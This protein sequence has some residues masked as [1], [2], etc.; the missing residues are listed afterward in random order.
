MHIIVKN[1]DLKAYRYKKDAGWRAVCRHVGF[2]YKN[3]MRLLKTA[4]LDHDAKCYLMDAI[5]EVA[6][7]NRER[8]KMLAGE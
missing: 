6:A 5:D 4:E 3:F 8:E 1:L 7:R 2:N